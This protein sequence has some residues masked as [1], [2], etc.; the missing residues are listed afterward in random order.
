LLQSP[1][2]GCCVG[3]SVIV[4][5]IDGKIGAAMPGQALPSLLLVVADCAT[6]LIWKERPCW[7]S[8][9]SPQE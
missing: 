1:I 4:G 5:A 8:P 9:F 3:V 2:V 7:R 6:H